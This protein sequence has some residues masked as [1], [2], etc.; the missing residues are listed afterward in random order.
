MRTIRTVRELRDA[1]AEARKLDGSIGFV[2]T[3]GYLH[4]GH[5]ALVQA[6]RTRCSTTVLSIF[7]NPTQFGPKEDL[8]VYPRNFHRDERLC[9]DAGV[10]IIFAPETEEVYPSGFETFIEPGASAQPLCGPFRL[11]HFRGVATVVCKL[12]NMVQPDLAFFGQKDFQQCAVVRRMVVDLNLPI[13][14]VTVPTVRDPDGLAMSSRNRYLSALERDRALSISRG[15]FAA[16]AAFQEGELDPARLLSIAHQTME[17]VDE[18]Q[19][20]E[21]V[22]AE[23]ITPAMGELSR[24][25]AICVAGYIGSTRLIDNILLDTKS[26]AR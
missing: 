5:L 6:S 26:L 4:E 9:R 2:P 19:Y 20:L 14:I 22:D 12:F 17:E 1:L 8:S 10:N 16:Q 7:V 13:E 11:G 3:M 24:P 21:I 25:A 15:L 18:L 23:T